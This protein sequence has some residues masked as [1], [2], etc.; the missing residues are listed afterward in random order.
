[1]SDGRTVEA[2]SWAEFAGLAAEWDELLLSTPLPL[3]FLCHDWIRLWWEHFGRGAEFVALVLRAEDRL[4]AAVP[5]ALRRVRLA[6]A[7]ATVAEIAGTGPVVTRGMGLADKAD[8]LVRGGCAGA[9]ECVAHALAGLL[10]AADALDLKGLD[11]TSPSIPALCAAAPRPH[12]ARVVPRSSSPY[13]ELPGSWDD[14]LRSRSGN[15]RKQLRKSR[16]L[17]EQRGRIDVARLADGAD[18]RGPMAE[19]VAIDAASWKADRG[20]ALFGPPPLRAFLLDVVARL[21][22]RGWIDL[23][24]LRLDGRPVAHELC[25]DLAGR[26]FSY[27]SGYRRDLARCSPGTALTAHVLEQ[28][29]ARGRI[30][31]DLLRG[32]EAYKARWG[33]KQRSEVELVF[34]AARPRARVLAAGLALRARARR[35]RWLS[36]LDD[37][38]SGLLNRARFA[39]RAD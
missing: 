22:A 34:A 27:N 5:V 38:A 19:V 23:H 4:D 31:Y 12:A 18:T 32:D 15:F 7:A 26:V 33:D 24:V 10:A 16:R 6:G 39:R 17:L 20:T 28:A 13:V 21:H 9:A 36:T 1:M 30:E 14:Y 2:L 29:C 3:P 25:F 35:W 11:A 8:L 37:R